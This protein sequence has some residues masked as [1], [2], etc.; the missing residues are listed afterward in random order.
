MAQKLDS[1]IVSRLRMLPQWAFEQ[2]PDA[3]EG[4][5]ARLYKACR[6]E[7]DLDA[8]VSAAATKRYALSRLRRMIMCAALGVKAG[9][10]EES[11]AYIRVLAANGRGCA[12]IKMMHERCKLPVVTKPGEINQLGREAR[13]LFALESAAT[14]LFSLGFSAREERRGDRDWR[15]S[16]F[17]M[18]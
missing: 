6:T 10:N 15:T 4:L 5:G 16:P 13:E 7:C 11:P 8:I 17:I 18:K 9:M 12:I 1:A 3:S 14:D 2:L